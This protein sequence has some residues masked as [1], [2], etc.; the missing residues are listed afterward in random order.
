MKWNKQRC[1]LGTLVLYF[2]DEINYTRILLFY[3]PNWMTS[4]TGDLHVMR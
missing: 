4:D 2:R 1:I 3:R